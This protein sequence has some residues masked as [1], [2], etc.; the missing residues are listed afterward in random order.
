VKE[1]GRSIIAAAP[2]AAVTLDAAAVAAAP[3]SA[4]G[5]ARSADLTKLDKRFD[6]VQATLA[7]LQTQ[8]TQAAADATLASANTQR[9][10]QSV[11]NQV[12]ALDNVVLAV[13]RH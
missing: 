10:T 9:Q 5:C 6:E 13:S 4:G 11:A 12:S 8:S 7:A 2:G 1:T 3:D